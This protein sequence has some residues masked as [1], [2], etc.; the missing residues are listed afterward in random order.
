M[1]NVPYYR[2][3]YRN[4]FI[5]YNRPIYGN[6]YIKDGGYYPAGKCNVLYLTATG[7]GTIPMYEITAYSGGSLTSVYFSGNSLGGASALSDY[8]N[9]VRNQ[10]LGGVSYKAYVGGTVPGTNYYLFYVS[11]QNGYRFIGSGISYPYF[12][13]IY[14]SAFNTSALLLSYPTGLEGPDIIE[15]VG[16]P[17]SVLYSSYDPSFGSVSFNVP[18][19]TEPTPTPTP[20]SGVWLPTP[21][22]TPSVTASLTVTPT[23]SPT[24]VCSCTSYSVVNNG[25]TSGSTSYID[26]NYVSQTIG[27]DA[28]QGISFCG[29]FNTISVTNRDMT[30]TNLGECIPPTPSTTPTFTPT[31]SQ[32]QP[33]LTP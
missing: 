19:L 17:P 28:G 5:G 3:Q 31:P 8:N 16:Y 9:Y 30:I 26:C 14:S 21:T 2:T 24:F 11:D 7:L 20:T 13:P 1:S 22:P 12:D 15:G 6:E 27:L 32:T 18:C 29:C 4:G 33:D 23:P 10:P 25:E